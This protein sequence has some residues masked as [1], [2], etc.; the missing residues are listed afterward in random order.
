LPKREDWITTKTPQELRKATLL[1][2]FTELK[3]LK[4]ELNC[5]E[6]FLRNYEKYRAE[7]ARRGITREQIEADIVRMRLELYG[8]AGM[9]ELF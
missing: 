6:Y 1:S 8:L 7:L 9:S 2:R 5:A 4:E 3:R